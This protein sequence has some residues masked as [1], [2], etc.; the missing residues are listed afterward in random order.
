MSMPA[1][2]SHRRHI[3]LINDYEKSAASAS[4]IY[5]SDAEPGILRKRSG[6]G[7]SYTLS[8]KPLK[9]KITIERIRKLAI[10]PAW[11]AV[12]I[13]RSEKGHIQATGFD[14]KKRK[15]YRYHPLWTLLRNDTKFHKMFEFGKVLPALR[16]MIEKDLASGDL[17]EKNVLATVVSLM[18]RTDIRI[19][20]SSYEKMNGSHGLTTLHDKHVSVQGAFISFSFKG[21]KDI[22]HNI[23]ITSRR[24]ASLVQKCR[25][26]PGKELFQYYDLNGN[27]KT[28][29]SGRVNN[30]IQEIMQQEFSA[31]DF[32]TWAGC[33]HFLQAFK[34]LSSAVPQANG[35]MAVNALLDE[36]SKKLGNTRT[37]CRKYYVHPGII[38]LYEEDKLNGYMQELD[39]PEKNDNVS[40]LTG[41]EV[42]LM[43]ILKKML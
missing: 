2:I 24:L 20:N 32:R 9:D 22:S 4:L 8:E 33:L 39:K 41:N 11:E 30:Y 12:W 16:L 17:S 36:V 18:Q 28:V 10:P 14:A 19:G 21:K 23:K 7:F 37:V 27:R 38:K 15:Q 5:V 1:K 25:D 26:I 43:N 13:C 3:S 35:K 42:V 31:K 34:N 6:K 40:G 29:D